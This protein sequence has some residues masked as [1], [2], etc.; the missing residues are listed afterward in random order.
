MVLDEL[1]TFRGPELAFLVMRCP[2]CGEGFTSYWREMGLGIREP[3][4]Q[5][6]P[7]AHAWAVE[8][9][10]CSECHRYI[11]RLKQFALSTRTEILG[12]GMEVE[13]HDPVSF[14]VYPKGTARRCP[15]EVPDNLREDFLEAALVLPD[16]PKASAALSRRCLQQLLR[17]HVGIERR[18]LDLEIQE[19][20]STGTLPSHLAD[21]IDG[22]RHIGNFAAH[23]LKST[24]TGEILRVEEGEADWNLETLVELFDF[25]FVAPARAAER[26]AALNARLADAGKPP[27]RS[28]PLGPQD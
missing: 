2:H 3:E 15:P 24:S 8:W 7:D 21:A 22:V 12:G 11:V 19:L 16:S 5:P 20:L 26:Q 25:Y 27:M 23:P 14:Q 6:D 9:D 1:S 10:Q 17:E 28:G 13:T 4:A 18:T